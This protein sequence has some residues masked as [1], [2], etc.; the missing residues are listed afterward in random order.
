MGII[1]QATLGFWGFKFAI[2][3]GFT[4]VWPRSKFDML[5]GFKSNK[6][7]QRW[8]H[9]SQGRVGF[10]SRGL[11]LPKTHSFSMFFPT[12]LCDIIR[13]GVPSTFPLPTSMDPSAVRPRVSLR[14]N[15]LRTTARR[16][17]E[18]SWSPHLVVIFEGNDCSIMLYPLSNVLNYINHRVPQNLHRILFFDTLNWQKSISTIVTKSTSISEL[19][20]TD[21]GGSSADRLCRTSWRS[22]WPLGSEDADLM[23]YPQVMAW[24]LMVIPKLSPSWTKKALFW[25]EKDD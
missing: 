14:G 12:V 19:V 21:F 3:S 1:G 6:S 13:G 18:W 8:D 17:H 22:P 11:V 2:N 25:G 20:C 4:Q 5:S 10:F 16:R 24:L 9:D 23:G 15:T 7:I